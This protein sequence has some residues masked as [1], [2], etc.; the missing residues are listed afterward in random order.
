[1]E[2][3][4]IVAVAEATTARVEGTFQ[5]H[6]SP[7]VEAIRGSS[8]GGRWGAPGSYSV[9]YL[10]RPTDSVI[11]EAYR[12][13]VD[14]DPDGGLTGDMVGPRNLLTCEVAV[15]EILDLRDPRSQ[16]LVGLDRRALTSPVDEY[17]AC[18]R[19]GQAAHQLDLR[20]VIA[21]AA[22]IGAGVAGETL[23]VF[24]EKLGPDEHPVHTDTE[25]WDHLPPDPRRLRLVDERGA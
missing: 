14:D 4:L 23:A 22:G 2:R 3:R 25:R 7:G 1:M 5:R 21:P 8:G 16:A 24:E 9:L 19:V 20:G 13:L 17:A 12:H 11:V 18:Q 15:S 10:G 6:A